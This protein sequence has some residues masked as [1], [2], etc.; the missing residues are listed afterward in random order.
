MRC[1]HLHG[2][3]RV[4][5]EGPLHK[6]KLW[7]G[8]TPWL[9]TRHGDQR[10]LLRDP[11][12][13]AD[14]SHP[15]YPIP[16]PAKQGEGGRSTVSFILMDDQEHARLRRMVTAPFAVKNRRLPVPAAG[17]E[18]RGARDHGEHDLPGHARAARAP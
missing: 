2:E 4:P 7:N 8:M 18:A 9:I 1:D 11:R 15:G 5:G 10:K 14:G 3:H 17:E 16:V 6:V 13:S 12:I